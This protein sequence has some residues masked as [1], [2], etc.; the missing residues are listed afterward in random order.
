MQWVSAMSAQSRRSSPFHACSE[1][2]C[3]CE[4]C[5][6]RG[7]GCHLSVVEAVKMTERC[8]GVDDYH[9]RSAALAERNP[10]LH[11]N[12]L[13]HRLLFTWRPSSICMH[14]IMHIKL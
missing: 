10:W 3:I 4:S 6:C 12:E 13:N 9:M 1:L 2:A 8:A 5:E 7:N 14:V 11:T